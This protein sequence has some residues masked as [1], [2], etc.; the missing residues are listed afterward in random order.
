MSQLHEQT[1]SFG[2][3]EKKINVFVLLFGIL[4]I[5]TLLTYFLPTGEYARIEVNDRTT[6]DPNSFK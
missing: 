2:K 6:V 5:A 4:V 1:V 3:K